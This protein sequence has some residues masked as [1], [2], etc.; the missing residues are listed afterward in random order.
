MV[1]MGQIPDNLLGFECS[2]IVRRI[3][4]GVTKFKIGDSVTTR[5]VTVG[6]GHVS[7]QL[8]WLHSGLGVATS[9]DVRVTWPGGDVGPWMTVAADGFVRIERG[10]AEP[11]PWTPAP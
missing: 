6:G 2:G 10:A 4:R 7:G 1:A 8:G 3:G 11:T 5:E 9:A